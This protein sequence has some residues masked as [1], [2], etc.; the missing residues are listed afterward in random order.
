MCTAVCRTSLTAGRRSSPPIVWDIPDLAI[1]K[2]MLYDA[3]KPSVDCCEV[4]ANIFPMVFRFWNFSRSDWKYAKFLSALSE[5]IFVKCSKNLEGFMASFED[6]FSHSRHIGCCWL[7]GADTNPYFRYSTLYCLLF[8]LLAVLWPYFILEQK[9]KTCKQYLYCIYLICIYIYI[10]TI[11]IYI[12][13]IYVFTNTLSILFHMIDFNDVF[14]IIQVLMKYDKILYVTW[15]C[16]LPRIWFWYDTKYI[17]VWY[18]WY[19]VPI[20]HFVC[21]YR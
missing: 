4:L 15:S 1:S 18:W 11:Y 14:I 21:P 9:N 17:S 5:C 3:H 19:A 10:Y 2:D 7:C 16:I 20:K 13:M 12:Y 8:F 6:T